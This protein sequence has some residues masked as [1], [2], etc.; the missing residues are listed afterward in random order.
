MARRYEEGWTMPRHQKLKSLAVLIGISPQELQFGKLDPSLHPG[1]VSTT[2]EL[3]PDEFTLLAAYRKLPPHGK[4]SL[5][6]H[7]R[8]LMEEFVGADEDNPYGRRAET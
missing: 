6:V 4:E 5:R 3:T 1:I 8:R 2:A 7:V